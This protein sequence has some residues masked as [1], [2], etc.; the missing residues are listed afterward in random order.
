MLKEMLSSFNVLS[1]TFVGLPIASLLEE[2]SVGVGGFF[3]EVI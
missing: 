3:F 2:A 1:C